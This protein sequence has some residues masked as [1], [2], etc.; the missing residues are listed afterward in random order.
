MKIACLSFSE[1]GK[2]LGEKIKELSINDDKYIVHHFSNREIEGGIRSLMVYLAMEYDGLVFISATGI[3]VRLMNP[4]IIDKTVDPAVV[5]V[6]DMGNFSI[7]L[8][9]GHIG[10]GN[11]LAKWIGDIIGATPVITTASDNRGIEAI[12]IFSIKNNYHMK[13]MKA[14][15]NITAMMV[16]GKKIGFYSEMDKIIEYDNL[17]VLES[18]D[19][20]DSN[21]DG[22][23]IVSSQYDMEL[24]KLKSKYEI[25]QLIPRNINIG[26]G[27]RRGIEGT[28]IIEAIRKEL[29]KLNIY[30]KGIKNIGTVEVKKDEV[31]IIETAKYFDCPLK[32][33]TLDEILEV[34]E[35]FEKSQFVKNTIG[36]YSV[37]EPSAY[38]LGGEL[39]TSKSKHKGITISIAREEKNG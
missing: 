21:I 2:K 24:E 39:L 33:F 30:T 7:S 28:K 17:V 10:G 5:V 29:G 22:I 9:S 12:D 8:L 6:D 31:G 32:I 11:E 37:S 27:C 18:L 25:C 15:K 26:V 3:A 13:N 16:D 1:R 14:V 36:V 38:L 19:N 20:I 4:Y 23:I 35:K 34:E